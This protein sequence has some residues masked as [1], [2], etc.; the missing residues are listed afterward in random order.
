MVEA[1]QPNVIDDV[2]QAIRTN[3]MGR[4]RIYL[5]REERTHCLLVSSE[6]ISDTSWPHC[7]PLCVFVPCVDREGLL[8][9][10]VLRPRNLIVLQRCRRFLPFQA[11]ITI[12]SFE[13]AS[14]MM[15][16]RVYALYYTQK[17]V[18]VS[19]ALLHFFGT[20]VV[21]WLTTT[22][23]PVLHNPNS[24]VHLCAMFFDTDITVLATAAAWLPFLFDTAVLGL[25]L[26]RTIPSIRDKHLSYIMKRLLADGVVYY[27]AI[28]SVALLLTLMIIAAPPGL[29]NICVQL[30]L[31][32][33]VT[34]MSRI[35]LNLKKSV[36]KLYGAENRRYQD[37]DH[38]IHE[39]PATPES[40]LHFP[41]IHQ[42]VPDNFELSV[43]G[44][45]APMP[46]STSV[47]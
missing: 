1:S 10:L 11:V 16:L 41:A 8:T 21:I 33:T 43:T 42:R 5:E 32:L 25:I 22:G 3:C 20:S 36:T 34:M 39:P 19:V 27:S 14:F 44:K 24:G 37:A 40:S 7:K 9:S 18:V 30:E 29:K 6:S 13:I 2:S 26:H 38:Y 28:F 45:I 35:T 46:R 15:L 4:G 47:H 31:T 23:Q 12:I 17:W